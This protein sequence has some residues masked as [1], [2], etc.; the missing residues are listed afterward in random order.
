LIS[1][2]KLCALVHQFHTHS[3]SK[4]EEHSP[5]I[6]RRISGVKDEDKFREIIEYEIYL[7]HGFF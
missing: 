4:L 6:R 7:H 5:C 3:R 1:L 2:P